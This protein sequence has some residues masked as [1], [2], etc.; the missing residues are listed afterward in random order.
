LAVT[1]TLGACATGGGETGP[2]SL[3]E[4]AGQPAPPQARFYAD[5]ITQAA[6]GRTYDREGSTLRFRCSG[7]PAQAF[8][9]GLAG[10]SAK[11]GSER[12]GEGRTW[13]FTSP[14]ER[15]PSGLDFCTRDAAGDYSCTVVLR[16]GEFLDF[17]G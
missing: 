11:A 12:T 13:R 1:T 10:W 17:A 14:M 2:P 9:E 15:D 5:C 8:Y 3:V 7:G 6:A 16:V 4:A